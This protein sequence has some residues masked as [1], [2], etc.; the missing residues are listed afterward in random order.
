M[1]DAR[2]ARPDGS[3]LLGFQR[4]VSIVRT[5]VTGVL[6]TVH[7]YDLPG[8]SFVAQI[9]NSDPAPESIRFALLGRR[10]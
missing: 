7:F 9:F 5:R 6:A 3:G 8:S 1:E 2:Y 4:E 10:N